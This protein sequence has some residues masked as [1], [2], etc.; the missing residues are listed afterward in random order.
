[1]GCWDEMCSNVPGHLTKI[2][3]RP[4]YG[5]NFQKHLL[6]NQES[7]DR[8]TWYTASGTTKFVQMMTLG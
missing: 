1:M 2:A 6:R 4:I 7:D 3:S 8:K 5:T